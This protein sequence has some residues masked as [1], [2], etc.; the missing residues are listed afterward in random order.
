MGTCLGQAEKSA[1]AAEKNK[2]LRTIDDLEEE[3]ERARDL[4]EERR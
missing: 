1:T 3:L 2:L 4:C